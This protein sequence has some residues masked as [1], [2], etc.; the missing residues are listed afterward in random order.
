MKS[1]FSDY[2]TGISIVVSEETKEIAVIGG[3][4]RVKISYHHGIPIIS[5]NSA[6]STNKV[7]ENTV[8]HYEDGESLDNEIEPKNR[9][10]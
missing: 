9:F 10:E 1:V 7:S 3:G 6:F 2:E 5:K 4:K 8:V